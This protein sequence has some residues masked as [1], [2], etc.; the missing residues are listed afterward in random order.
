MTEAADNI[1]LDTEKIVVDA[2]SANKPPPG[3]YI[4]WDLYG[5]YLQE[6]DYSDA[7]KCELISV[8][9]SIAVSFAD[10]GL[11]IHPAQ[12][13]AQPATDAGP[14]PA[15]GQNGRSMPHKVEAGDGVMLSLTTDIPENPNTSIAA[16]AFGKAAEREES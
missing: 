1:E 6:A 5:Q 8:L 7:E 14:R 13:A 2:L 16:V 15:C 4:D 10:L 3:L 9:W 12:L 11:G